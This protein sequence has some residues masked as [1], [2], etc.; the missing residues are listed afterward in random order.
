VI[1]SVLLYN[2]LMA[3]AVAAG[4]VLV[5]RLPTLVSWLGAC[6]VG[7]AAAAWL[8]VVLGDGRFGIALLG[9][10]GLF[11]HGTVFLLVSAVLLWRA[12]RAVA[13]TS[14]V[15]ALAVVAV[16]VDCFLIEPTWLTVSYHRLGSPKLTRPVRIVLVADVQTD[17]FGRYEKEVFQ[18][19]LQQ[20]PDL[21]LLAGDYLQIGPERREQLLKSANRFL[22]ELP[23]TAPDGVFAVRGNVDWNDW[24]R[25]F[26]GTEVTA[27][28]KTQS[29]QAAGLL[30]TCLS[31]PDSFR[32][33]MSLPSPRPEMFRIVLGHSPD[34]ALGAVEA[35]LMM[36][37]HTHGGQVHLPGIGPLV[38]PARVPRRW[39]CGLTELPDGGRLLVS[40]GTGM[41]RANAPRL[42]FLC[43]PELVVIDLVPE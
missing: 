42:R 10:Y 24:D 3:A 18:K 43:R 39:G 14:G 29:F 17:T 38:I 1:F 34:F 31:M 4:L 21:I 26:Q 16:A 23:L 13:I 7:S 15:L 11:L 20:E 36:A 32:P 5:G 8:S 27:V 41:E 35:D 19:A 12:R 37:G 30:L 28:Q 40:R 2:A 22:K 9:A 25:L 6:V 33:R